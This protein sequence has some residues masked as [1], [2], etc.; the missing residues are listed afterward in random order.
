MEAFSD[1]VFAIAATLLILDIHIGAPAGGLAHALARE[2]PHYV[3][4]AVSFVTIGIIWVNHH[5]QFQ[6]IAQ[7][8]RTLLFINLGLLMVVAFIPFPT[9]LLAQYLRAPDD[10]HV[11]AALYAGT[12]LLL[13]IAFFG[14]WRYAATKRDL[15]G[16]VLSDRDVSRLVRRNL[17]GMGPYALAI[18]IAFI[19]A[20]ASLA[21]C[22]AV[23]AYYVLP[24]RL[25]EPDTSSPDVG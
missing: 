17:M 8:D 15:L 7:A 6:V 16:A 20:P 2:W 12:L 10:Q 25:P 14:T 11:A 9:G 5:A 1:G 13:S 18:G 3:T 4:F 21:I 19:S 24:G 22:A 23:A